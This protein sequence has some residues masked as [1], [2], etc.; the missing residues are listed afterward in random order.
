M[1]YLASFLFLFVSLVTFGQKD[2]KILLSNGSIRLN[3]DITKSWETLKNNPN[4]KFGAHVYALLQ[5][6]DIPTKADKT[7]LKEQ[8]IEL[9]HYV[10]NYAWIAKINQDIPIETLS[11]LKLK[12]IS[13][14]KTSWKLSSALET[15]NIPSH[16]GN[17]DLLSARV[18]FWKEKNNTIDYQKI[19]EQAG[20]HLE[21]SKLESS[22]IEVN[23]SWLKLIDFATHPLVQYIEFKTPP[24]ENEFKEEVTLIQSNYISDNIGQGLFFDG[25]GVAIA[26]NEGGHIDSTHQANFRNRLDRS[27]ETGNVSGHKT[28]VGRRMASAGNLNPDFRGTAFGAILLSGG[29]NFGDAATN[30]ITIVNNSFGYGCIGSGTTSTYNS[31]AANNDNLV[32]T[33][34]S[35]MITYSCGNM[36][37]SDCGYGNGAAGAGWGNITGLVKSA[38]NIFAVGALNTEGNLTRS[39]LDQYSPTLGYVRCGRTE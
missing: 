37:G 1:K 4:S 28:G 27:L 6:E 16:A 23:A 25:T 29:I 31:G 12:G 13:E 36:G 8:G 5:L 26:V 33:N 32:R 30:G 11:Q 7:A 24:Q 20:L 10:P 15:A 9:L 14:F 18:L 19:C 34:P 21:R 17:I 35:F 3:A 39:S 22:W 2:Y 38:K